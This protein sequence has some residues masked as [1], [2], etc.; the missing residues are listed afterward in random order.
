[1]TG[2]VDLVLCELCGCQ[3]SLLIDDDADDWLRPSPFGKA[4]AQKAE[5]VR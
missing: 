3:S 4:T 1:M 2:L 5:R